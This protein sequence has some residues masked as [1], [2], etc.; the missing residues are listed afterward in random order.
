MATFHEMTDAQGRPVVR[1]FVKGAPDVLIARGAYVWMPDGERVAVTDENRHL[2]LEEND[3]MAKAG[4][5]VMVVARRDF[6]PATFDRGGDLLASGRR[7]HAAGDGRHRRPT[8]AR[9]RATPSP[10]ARA[11]ASRCG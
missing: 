11:P 5:R 4:E 2:A 3:R 1:C 6:D 9:R 10:S 8:P 7:P